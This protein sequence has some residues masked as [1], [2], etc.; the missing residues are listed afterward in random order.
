MRG[1]LRGCLSEIHMF[2]LIYCRI[3]LMRHTN[4][5]NI[6]KYLFAMVYKCGVC[7]NVLRCL[8]SGMA[9]KIQCIGQS[10]G[11]QQ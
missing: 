9:L 2:F 6:G 11:Y 4:I 10:K 3:V 7:T 1:R 8:I 5:S